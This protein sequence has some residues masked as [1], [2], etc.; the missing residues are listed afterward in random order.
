MAEHSK[1]LGHCIQF[2]DTRIPTTKTGCM[3]HIIKE[4]IETEPHSD[5]I[6]RKEGFSQ[7]KV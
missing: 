7:S 4:A 5:N 2:Q 6:N 1:D 3:E